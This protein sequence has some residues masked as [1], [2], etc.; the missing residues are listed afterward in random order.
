[1]A[2]KKK[3]RLGLAASGHSNMPCHLLDRLKFKDAEKSN[4]QTSGGSISRALTDSVTIHTPYGSLMQ[5][6]DLPAASGGF[7]KLWFASPFAFLWIL[8]SRC[9]DFAKLLKAASV[10]LVGGLLFYTDEATCGNNLRPDNAGELQCIYWSLAQLP[11]WFRCRKNGWFVF[12]YVKTEDQKK[13]AGG[14]SGLVKGIMMYLF[15][16]KGFNLAVGMRLPCG[17]DQHFFVKFPL[18]CALQDEKAIKAFN[19]TKG[20][21][22]WKCCH[23]CK[24]IMNTKPSKLEN[25]DYLHHYALAVPS[26]FDRHTTE[27]FYEM[28][29]VLAEVHGKI[30]PGKFELLEKAYGVSHRPDGILLEKTLRRHYSIID[31]TYWDPM[32]MLLSSGGVAQYVIN[33]FV[34]AILGV[35]LPGPDGTSVPVTLEA[36]DAFG[37]QVVFSDKRHLPKTFFQKRIVLTKDSHIKC[38]AAEALQALTVLC[39]FFSTVLEPLKLMLEH[40]ECLH[41]LK[42]ICDIMF[43]CSSDEAV[44]SLSY[45]RELVAKHH[46]MLVGIFGIG[47]AKIK[48]HLL[49]H[50]VDCLEKFGIKLNCFSCER[51]HKLG[52]A[53]ARHQ[54][55]GQW[56]LYVL[57]RVLAETLSDF[58][59]PNLCTAE[60][61]VQPV[62]APELEELMCS[63]LQRKL[64][65]IYASTTLV[66]RRG[67]LVKGTLIVL[68]AGPGDFQVGSTIAFSQGNCLGEGFFGVLFLPCKLVGLNT[69]LTWGNTPYIRPT[70]HIRAALPYVKHGRAFLPCFPFGARPQL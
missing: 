59:Q 19:N 34:L 9:N 61:L 66:Y 43:G 51:L 13:I 29:D 42:Q 7:H 11:D 5:S 58:D 15:S 63:G 40:G 65:S 46:Q 14:L 12:S 67:C 33:A 10:S 1:M 54:R 2:P 39:L 48:T 18:L 3:Q 55:A 21:A 64:S 37:Q 35:E 38:F 70:S 44:G 52:K 68:S 27:T 17:K 23:D 31:H 41:L 32:H 50:C 16:Q 26:Q 22:G 56:E 6:V 36:L 4:L 30:P 25:H 28:V 47:I 69:W 49:F 62:W 53:L 24:N 45:L 8:C 57:K 20:A 60:Y